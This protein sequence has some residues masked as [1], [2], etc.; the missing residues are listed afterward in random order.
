[1]STDAA[2]HFP[3]WAATISAGMLAAALTACAGQA[4]PPLGSEPP[5]GKPMPLPVETITPPYSELAIDRTTGPAPTVPW[6]L[7]K[8]DP[9]ENRIYLSASTSGCS[10]P[11]TVRVSETPTTVQVT[12][13]GIGDTEPCSMKYIT[14]IGY[15]QFDSM[16]DRQVIGN[17][18]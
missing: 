3:S 16:G 1:M 12:V 9:Q 2:R 11:K 17:A 15:I 5:T 18:S 8:V 7:M 4:G 13:T 14:L 6:Q 10:H